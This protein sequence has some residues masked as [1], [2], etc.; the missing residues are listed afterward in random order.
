MCVQWSANS[1]TR[2][3]PSRVHAACVGSSLAK[4]CSIVGSNMAELGSQRAVAATEAAGKAA[5]YKLEKDLSQV[6]SSMVL[7]PYSGEDLK[8]ILKAAEVLHSLI[9]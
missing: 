3:L 5:V 8:E 1:A 6:E 9:H 2:I 7:E 4:V